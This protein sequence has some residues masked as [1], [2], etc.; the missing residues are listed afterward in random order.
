MARCPICKIQTTLIPYEGLR[1]QNCP[2]CGGYWLDAAK[3]DTV[4]KKRE[5]EMPPEVQEKMLEIAAASDS[6]QALACMM[7]G[8]MMKKRPF[9]AVP[10][11]VLDHCPKCGGVWCDKGELEKL[12]ILWE[13]YQDNPQVAPNRAARERMVELDA[14]MR[15][16]HEKLRERSEDLKDAAGRFRYG[17]WSSQGAGYGVIDF[18]CGVLLRWW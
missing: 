15:L 18:L 5:I 16:E 13:R 4:L 2:G 12:Q 11:V 8:T 10:E 6:K 1:I 14:Q 9:R 17:G 7:C 3:L